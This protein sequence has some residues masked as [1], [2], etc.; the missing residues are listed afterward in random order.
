VIP[1]KFEIYVRYGHSEYSSWEI[2][3]LATSLIGINRIHDNYV[4]AKNILEENIKAG[5][6]SPFSCFI[7]ELIIMTAKISNKLTKP[8]VKWFWIYVLFRPPEYFSILSARHTINSAE[9]QDG[10]RKMNC[11]GLNGSDRGLICGTIS[12]TVWKDWRVQQKTAK[13]TRLQV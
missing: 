6:C 13:I 2:K 1:L 12:A 8:K 5:Q 3:C 11:K 10:K 7:Y 9:L 4:T